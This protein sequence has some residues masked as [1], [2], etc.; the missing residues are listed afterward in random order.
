MTALQN[1]YN[2]ISLLKEETWEAVLPLFEESELK[3]DEYFVRQNEIARKIAFLE[4]GVVRA[5]F[6]DQKGEDYNKQFFVGHSSIGAY[7]SLLTGKPNLV[8]QQ[9]MTDCIIWTCDFSSLT[10]LYSRYHLSLIHI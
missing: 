2:S 7:S 1:F 8:A 6:I 10:N 5:F 4:S 3:A 9:A